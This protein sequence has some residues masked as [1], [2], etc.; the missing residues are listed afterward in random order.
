VQDKQD[1][2]DVCGVYKEQPEVA[3]DLAEFQ[4][5]AIAKSVKRRWKRH[6]EQSAKQEEQGEDDLPEIC[7]PSL[8][9]NP[10]GGFIPMI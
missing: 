10:K 5:V 1:Q 8:K 2:K 3:D 6:K 9:P 7:D 4:S